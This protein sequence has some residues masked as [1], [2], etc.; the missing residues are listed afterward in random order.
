M[1]NTLHDSPNVEGKLYIRQKVRPLRRGYIFPPEKIESFRSSSEFVGCIRK[2]KRTPLHTILVDWKI[3]S[4]QSL[5]KDGPRTPMT[6]PDINDTPPPGHFH[7]P[8]I[9]PI[10]IH[11]YQFTHFVENN[12]A[13]IFKLTIH[14]LQSQILLKNTIHVYASLIQQLHTVI[15]IVLTYTVMYICSDRDSSHEHIS[16]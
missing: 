9:T 14:S 10:A 8:H 5:P 2:G 15:E 6:G 12:P 7:S 11:V 4:Q 1:Q 13:G 3:D 16:P